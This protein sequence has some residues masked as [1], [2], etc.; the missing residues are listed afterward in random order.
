MKKL[1][2][3][4]LGAFL[5][6]ITSGQEVAPTVFAN[7][8]DRVD[9]SVNRGL[10]Y[11]VRSQLNDGSYPGSYGNSCGIPA[12]AGMA[13]LSRGHLPT[14]GPYADSLNKIIDFFGYFLQWLGSDGAALG[15]TQWG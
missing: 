12:L 8:K 6:V 10:N 5:V 9:P 4:I 11:L 13:F 1:F 14:E 7:W 2:S 15:E 3:L